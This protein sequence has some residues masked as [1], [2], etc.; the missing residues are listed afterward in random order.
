MPDTVKID[1]A[2]CPQL[3]LN[4]LCLSLLEAARRFYADPANRAAFESWAA[5]TPKGG[6]AT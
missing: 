4:G 3:V 5:S 2:R 6:A 1:L